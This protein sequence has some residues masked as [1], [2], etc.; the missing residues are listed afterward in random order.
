MLHIYLLAYIDPG[1]GTLLVQMLIA[2][3]IGATAFFRQ[4]IFGFFGFFKKKP[5]DDADKPK[6]DR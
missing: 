5:K 4:A 6:Q 2:G 1:S 3:L